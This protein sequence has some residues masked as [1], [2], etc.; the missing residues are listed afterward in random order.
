MVRMS[1]SF[2]KSY[3]LVHILFAG[4]FVFLE[5]IKFRQKNRL[6]HQINISKTCPNKLKGSQVGTGIYMYDDLMIFIFLMLS[7]NEKLQQATK[8]ANIGSFSWPADAMGF[9][10]PCVHL[11]AEFAR[12]ES[13]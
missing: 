5:N 2:P 8:I 3:Y 7:L 12:Q 4:F 11:Q 1:W 10:L 13:C 9:S 6:I